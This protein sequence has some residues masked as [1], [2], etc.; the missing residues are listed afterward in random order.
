[1]AALVACESLRSYNS[2]V[3]V[4]PFTTRCLLLDERVASLSCS[5]S[6]P[7]SACLGAVTTASGLFPRLPG[8]PSLS[9]WVGAR[10]SSTKVVN[11]RVEGASA[12]ICA[13]CWGGNSGDA[14]SRLGQQADDPD[15]RQQGNPELHQVGNHGH[16]LLLWFVALPCFRS[17]AELIQLSRGIDQGYACHLVGIAGGVRLH[18]HAAERVAHQ[19]VRAFDTSFAE[20]GVQFASDLLGVPRFGTHLAPAHPR[21]VVGAHTCGIGDFLL[22]PD[23]VSRKL[24]RP[25]IQHYGRA[26][27]AQTIYVQA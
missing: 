25:R 2:D 14:G 22:H 15:P 6:Q 9:V 10:N 4:A 12:S 16:T 26:A 19:H 5:L 11:S 20:Q 7:G 21:P 3:C 23:P 18:V 17:L 24:P 27:L 1:M 13:R 8:L